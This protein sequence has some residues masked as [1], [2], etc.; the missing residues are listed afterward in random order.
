MGRLYISAVNQIPG[1][2]L[3]SHEN[4]KSLNDLFNAID[5][6]L[7]KALTKTIDTTARQQMEEEVQTLDLSKRISKLQR[8][9]NNKCKS[10]VITFADGS[11]FEA[12]DIEEI[13]DHVNSHSTQSPVELYIRTMHGNHPTFF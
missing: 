9:Y 8:K 6:K 11:T 5:H 10:A 3:L 7:N 12:N 2:W 4:L 1:P 13:L